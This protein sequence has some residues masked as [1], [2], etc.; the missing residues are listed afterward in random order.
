MKQKRMLAMLLMSMIIFCGSVSVSA[1]TV[2]SGNGTEAEPYAISNAEEL[3]WFCEQVNNGATDIDAILTSDI[4]LSGTWT[5]IGTWDKIYTGT[6]DGQGKTISGLSALYDLDTTSEQVGLFRYNAGTI[7]NVIV[8]GEL[9][10]GGATGICIYNYSGGQ[11]INC[12]NYTQ[13]WSDNMAGGICAENKGLIRNCKNYGAISYVNGDNPYG[14]GGICADSSGDIQN[15]QNY[16][17]LFVPARDGGAPCT[18]GGIVCWFNDGTVTQCENR[19]EVVSAGGAGGIAAQISGA[20]MEH[21]VN[22]GKVTGSGNNNVA[23]VAGG[24]YDAIVRNC[25]NYGTVTAITAEAITGG[26]AGYTDSPI[27]GCINYGGVTAIQTAGGVYG[28]CEGS[29]R[30]YASYSLGGLVSVSE[31]GVEQTDVFCNTDEETLK[32]RETAWLMNTGGGAYDNSGVWAEGAVFANEEQKAVFRAEISGNDTGVVYTNPAGI[33]EELRSSFVYVD[34]NNIV[35]NTQT[36]VNSDVK[37]IAKDYVITDIRFTDENG[38]KPDEI[39]LGKVY[40]NVTVTAPESGTD[41]Q[42]VLAEYENNLFS[43]ADLNPK[44]V[45]GTETLQVCVQVDGEDVFGDGSWI[46]TWNTNLRLFI[47]NAS[48]RPGCVS[49][50]YYD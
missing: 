36:V 33:F 20:S 22:Y 43:E 46:V 40:A 38:E 3:V 6:F 28:R 31:I 49:L 26:V 30:A 29:G 9:T 27:I 12:V 44:T 11:I 17:Y 41:V 23:G 34:E 1:A 35:I 5:P 7:Q 19:G 15:C 18:A 4:A 25:I 2:P 16:G 39:P 37:L 8:S 24:V 14:I 47:W 32:L 10:A 48:L 42:V 45:R 13:I 21:C 50:G